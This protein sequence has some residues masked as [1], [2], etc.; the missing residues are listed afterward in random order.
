MRHFEEIHTDVV[1][2]I[3][4]D[5]LASELL[6]PASTEQ[7]IACGDDRYLSL[8]SLRIFRAGL[9]H[10]MVDAKWPAFEAAFFEFDPLAV[11]AMHDEALEQLASDARLIR[12]WSK[13]Q[14]VRSN[15]QQLVDI[16]SEYEG[17]GRYIAEWPGSEI[18]DLWADLQ[19][20]FSQL[21]GSS[22]ANF[23]RMAGRDTFLLTRDVVVALKRE[24]LCDNEPK[25][26]K[27]RQQLQAVF[28]TWAEQSQ[29]PLCQIS[30]ILAL[31]VA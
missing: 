7:L 28:N 26:K 4:A 31:S 15:A 22:G 8:M 17:F 24:G 19:N 6:V 13:L 1:S 14:A 30:K 9:K 20:Q 18:V 27:A 23:L 12:H 25:S 21:G 5:E 3:G 11:A 2:R 16:S 10:S 29:L